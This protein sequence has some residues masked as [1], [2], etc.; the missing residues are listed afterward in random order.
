[1]KIVL[2]IAWLEFRGFFYSPVAWLV[3]VAFIIPPGI[4]FGDML[5]NLQRQ[6][7]L[8]QKISDL[9]RT[10]CTA[11]YFGFFPQVPHLPVSVPPAAH[12]GAVQ[13]G[14]R[15]RLDETLYS[16]PVQARQIVL[17]KYVALM[18]YGLVLVGCWVCSPGWR[19]L[20]SNRWTSRL[21]CA[22]CSA[23]ILLICAYAA[24]GLSCRA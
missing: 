11:P 20:R 8:G 10:S 18:G 17:G 9:A 1:M 4:A 7:Y 2:R 16:S 24:I 14:T 5:E 12:H 21:C 22:A 3:L 15:G 6:Q 19:G 23:C 13:P